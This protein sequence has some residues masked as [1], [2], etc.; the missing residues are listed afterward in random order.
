MAQ[1]HSYMN[2]HAG[3]G[4]YDVPEDLSG[5][6][7]LSSASKPPILINEE[8]SQNATFHQE[9]AK[10]QPTNTCRTNERPPVPEYASESSST[11][12]ERREREEALRIINLTRQI[13][14]TFQTCSLNQP[15]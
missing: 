10:P 8:V 1:L 4:G 13:Q 2:V 3:T 12:E 14:R 7:Y 6:S 15:E 5:S 9:A 11:E